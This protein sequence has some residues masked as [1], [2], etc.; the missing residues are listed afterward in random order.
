MKICVH[1]GKFWPFLNAKKGANSEL[2]RLYPPNLVCMQ[3]NEFLAIHATVPS[4]GVWQ[5][6]AFYSFCNL[7]VV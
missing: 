2:V 7:F 1:E 4:Y 5:G 6:S 3:S